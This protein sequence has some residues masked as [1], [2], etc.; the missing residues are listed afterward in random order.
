VTWATIYNWKAKFG[1]FDVLR[2]KRLKEERGEREA[3]EASGRA[4][5]R[6]ESRRGRAMTA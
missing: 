3:E 5:A 6:S 2:A 4:D 1:G